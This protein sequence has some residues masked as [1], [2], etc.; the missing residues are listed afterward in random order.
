MCG[1]KAYAQSD[2]EKSQKLF[3]KSINFHGNKIT[4]DK[5]IAR[6]M[7]MQYGDSEF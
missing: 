5:I 1:K 6:E 4:K 2:K 3:I 7:S